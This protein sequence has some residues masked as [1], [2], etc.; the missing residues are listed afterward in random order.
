MLGTII[1]KLSSLL[2]RSAFL[3]SFIPLL[4]FLVANGVLLLAVH[5]PSRDWVLAHR[6]DP[7]DLAGAVIAFLIGSLLFVTINTRLREFLEG[8]FWPRALSAAFTESEQGRLRSLNE[9]YSRLQASR[10]TLD[11]KGN[12]WT[13]RLKAARETLPKPEACRYDPTGPV[14][15]EIDALRR[16][17]RRGELILEAQLA[18]AVQLLAVELRDNPILSSSGPDG[19][20]N[21]DQVEVNALIGYA[22]AKTKQEIIRLFNERQFNFP[23]T[24][25]APTEM[26]NIAL[27]IRSYAL[28]RY[29]LNVESFWTRLQKVM[30]SDP[31]YAVLQDAKV[32]LDFL[33]SM[34][35][36][37]AV[38]TMAW[39]I[40]LAVLGHSLEL[41][42]AI[43]LVGPFSMWAL[44]RLTLQNYRAF[45]DLMR[46]AIDMYRLR[47]LKELQL[48]E[49]TSSREE[50]AL[51]Q[52][53]QNRM[54]YGKDFN[55]SYRRAE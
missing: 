4:A 11:R 10:R 38:S 35:W 13:Q 28:S 9:A 27:S 17:R 22:G 49:P 45:A 18:R 25:L 15:S 51:W 41:Y 40:A 5:H 54:D 16:R 24:I 1:E 3:T 53:L 44:Y 39:L 42:L 8:R 14:A 31:F 12:Q 30:Q 55:L 6:R 26:G 33:V 36:L 46:S 48:P 37:S 43:A 7:E 47:L 34:F 23:D 2:S 21:D 29:Q 20:L 52:A 50:A 19:Q 32:Q